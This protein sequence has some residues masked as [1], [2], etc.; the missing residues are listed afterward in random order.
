M[1]AGI[2][3]LPNV[4]KSTLF[5]CLSNAKA[6]SANFPFCTIEPNLGIVNVPDP[7]LETLE[8]LV[9]PEKV[10]PATVEIVDI[11][12]LVKGASKGEGLGNQFLANIRETD[13]IIHVLRCFD[14]DN[15]VHVDGSV[16]PIRDKETI[17][18]E[19]Q[20]KDLETI[21][22]KLEKVDRSARTGNKEALK[23]Q[24]VLEVVKRAL[25]SAKNVR[26]LELK[27]DVRLKFIKPL[28]LIT[29]KPV[30]FVC[31]V[32]VV[33]A[34][35]GNNYVEQ[36]KNDLTEE[37][38]GLLLLAV[39]TEADINELESF[40]ERQMFLDDLGLE[41]AGAPKLIRAA[42]SL[43]NQQTFFTAGEKEVRAWTIPIGNTA[44][45]QLVL[46]ILILK[47]GL[48]EQK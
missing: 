21:E 19:L 7:R 20:L 15:I 2:V 48:L 28:Q 36:V 41:E 27:E 8:R 45:R 46:F 16:D 18:I 1:K 30:L 47:K 33:S 14:N 3:G 10:Q 34:M 13:A 38:A 40:E 35:T 5:N 42:Y 11:A 24:E 12:G 37:S 22:K 29:D 32:D 23:E 31:I 6:Q 17:D 44:P 25:E 26:S 9:K 39:S 4:G 43:L